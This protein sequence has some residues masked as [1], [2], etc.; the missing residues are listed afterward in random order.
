MVSAN[1][2][3][4][5]SADT[6]RPRFVFIQPGQ[7]DLEDRLTDFSLGPIPPSLRASIK[8]IGITHPAALARVGK[9]YRIV[10]GHR[11]TRIAKELGLENLPATLMPPGMTDEDMLAINLIENS[12]QRQYS[13]VEKGAILRKLSRAG[14]SEDRIIDKYM[15]IAGLERSKKLCQDFQAAESWG[16]GLKKL[17]HDLN[18]PL[19]VYSTLLRWDDA[20]RDRAESFFSALRPGVNK[21]RELLE[22]ID[23]ISRRDEERPGNILERKEIQAALQ[24]DTPTRYDKIHRVLFQW[25]FP[26]LYDLRKDVRSALDKLKLGRGIKVNAPE[27]FENGDIRIELKFKTPEELSALADE[28]S[29]ASRSDPMKDLIRVFKNLG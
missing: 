20:S 12:A 7:I 14:A 16:R 17:L 28:L 6:L 29:N 11:R 25:R 4:S 22:L 15:P 23:E 21:W 3:N 13:D 2:Y 26:V 19:R 27:N 24:N 1:S 5:L 18:V 10:C 8:K 9:R